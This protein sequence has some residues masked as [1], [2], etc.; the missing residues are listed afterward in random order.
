M[1]SD[2]GRAEVPAGRRPRWVLPAV[3]AVCVAAFTVAA[4]T[5]ASG[6]PGPTAATEASAA[7]ARA[8]AAPDEAVVLV[9]SS[10]QVPERRLESAPARSLALPVGSYRTVTRVASAVTTG[11]YPA[12]EE[13]LVQLRYRLADDRV[14]VLVRLPRS[15]MLRGIDPASYTATTLVV[16]GIDARA[17][18]GRTVEPTILLWSEGLRS[19]QLYSSVHSVAELVQLAEQLR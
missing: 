10:W 7:P 14:V 1:I 6:R 11:L 4:L 9:P 5:T 19:Y 17:L 18:T 2:L 13:A 15:E 16:R 8:A 3:T 12:D